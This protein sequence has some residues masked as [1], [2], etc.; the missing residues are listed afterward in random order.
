MEGKLEGGDDFETILCPKCVRESRRKPR[1]N[2]ELDQEA[3]PLDWEQNRI[4]VGQ[5][6]V[7]AR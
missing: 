3:L 5:Q 6:G 2:K 4:V 7:Q 1:G